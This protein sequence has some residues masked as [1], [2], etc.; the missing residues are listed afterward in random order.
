MILIKLIGYIHIN[1]MI[2]KNKFYKNNI[3]L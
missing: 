3:N 1:K 2:N